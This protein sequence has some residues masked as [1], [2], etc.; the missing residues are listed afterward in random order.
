MARYMCECIEEL[1]KT[2]DGLFAHLRDCHDIDVLEAKYAGRTLRQV[3]GK[4]M[5]ICKICNKKMPYFGEWKKDKKEW[6]N[7]CKIHKKFY[8]GKQGFRS[9]PS[10]LKYFD[11]TYGVH[12]GYIKGVAKPRKY[13]DGLFRR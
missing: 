5:R 9:L 1:F 6:K 11:V 3:S 2:V 13:L 4:L 8:C 10:L 7:H 12:C